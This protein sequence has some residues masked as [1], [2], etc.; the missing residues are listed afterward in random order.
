[1]INEPDV[2]EFG[3]LEQLCRELYIVLVRMENF[4]AVASDNNFSNLLNAR[5]A[6]IVEAATIIQNNS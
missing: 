1:M 2:S 3:R 5:N 6:K 4:E